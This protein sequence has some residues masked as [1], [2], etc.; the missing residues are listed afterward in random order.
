MNTI[1]RCAARLSFQPGY[2]SVPD[3]LAGAIL[4]LVC[5][6]SAPSSDLVSTLY[7]SKGGVACGAC[8]RLRS[9]DWMN[10]AMHEISRVAVGGGV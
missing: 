4:G 1:Q 6:L 10:I 7:K 3:P 2:K 5:L 8:R 9:C